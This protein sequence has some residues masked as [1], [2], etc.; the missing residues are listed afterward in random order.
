MYKHVI[1]IVN[2]LSKQLAPFPFLS[3]SPFTH[4]LLSTH[5]QGLGTDERSLIQVLAHVTKQE[6]ELIKVKMH[7]F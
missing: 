7:P 4:H 3:G 1:Q 2:K 5:S 6:V